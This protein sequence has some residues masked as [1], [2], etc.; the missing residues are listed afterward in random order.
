MLKIIKNFDLFGKNPDLYYKGNQKKTSWLGFILTVFYIIIYIAFFVYKFIRMVN[1]VDVT[2]YETYAFTGEIPSAVLNKEIFAGGIGLVNPKNGQNYIN[3]SIYKV[4][5]VY[6]RGKRI[7]GVWHWNDPINIPLVPCNLNYFG[8]RYQNTFKDKKLDQLYCFSDVEGLILEGYSNL[9]VYSYFDIS[10][11]RCVNET[12][13]GIC[14]PIEVIDEYL[15]AAQLSVTMQDIDLTPQDYESP[16]KEQEKD[17]PGPLY[18]DLHQEIYGYMQVTLLETEENIIGFEALSNIKTE[19]YLKYDHAWVIS[20]PNI[21]GNYKEEKGKFAPMTNIRIQLAN[22]VLTLKRYYVQLIDVLGDVGGLME[23]IYSLFNILSS[24]VVG[25]LY[26]E[27]LVNEL[28]SFDLDKKIISLKEKHNKNKINFINKEELFDLKISPSNLNPRK[29][30]I[31]NIDSKLNEELNLKQEKKES[32]EDK[33][34]K[35]NKENNNFTVNKNHGKKIYKKSGTQFIPSKV[36]IYGKKQIQNNN[37]N[38]NEKQNEDENSSKRELKLENNSKNNSEESKEKNIK[39]NS[40][41]KNNPNNNDLHG[42]VDRITLNKFLVH[43]FCCC[44]RIPKN[45]KN[46]LLDEGMKIIMEQLEIFNLF[47]KLYKEEKLQRNIDQKAYQIEMSKVFRNNFERL[48]KELM[49]KKDEASSSM[50][51]D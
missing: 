49:D 50:S 43:I 25:I 36:K 19:M 29:S 45:M 46:L 2:F 41:K 23:V 11:Y 21:Y 38:D 51:S 48:E 40:V 12:D 4:G 7:D 35:I 32:I 18:R 6:N 31:I 37:I 34:D 39:N 13:G 3:Q 44:I 28:F 42:I 22:K 1:K 8:S 27:S 15:T 17:I 14:L 10:F 16:I 5:A 30:A 47:M 33:E 20:S 9:N 26:E 24:I